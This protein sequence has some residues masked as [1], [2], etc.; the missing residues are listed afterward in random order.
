MSA[1]IVATED[2]LK[3]AVGDVQCHV[4]VDLGVLGTTVCRLQTWYAGHLKARFGIHRCAFA[5]TVGFIDIE[6]A[7]RDVLQHGDG[8]RTNVALRV[9]AAIDAVDAA[10]VDVHAGLSRAIA[11]VG[12]AEGFCS[13]P[14]GG[15]A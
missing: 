5:A 1:D 9:G 10:A 6:G 12:L 4:T 3:S 8:H 2:A 14:G 15:V 11:V 7:A 13:R